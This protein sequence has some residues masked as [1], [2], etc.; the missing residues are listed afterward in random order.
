MGG[1]EFAIL[2]NVDKEAAR[3]AHN[4]NL[5]D[6]VA[7]DQYVPRNEC[8]DPEIAVKA[9]QANI[10]ER[11]GYVRAENEEWQASGMHLGVGATIWDPKTETVE[12]AIGRA[13]IALEKH[14]KGLHIELGQYR[15]V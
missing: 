14:K 3:K 8:V 4:R 1:D 15:T 12:T 10:L 11:I 5:V 6:P 13:D 7:D 9:V 2:L